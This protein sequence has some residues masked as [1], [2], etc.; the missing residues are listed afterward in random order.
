MAELILARAGHA[1]H[2]YIYDARSFVLG[3]GLLQGCNYASNLLRMLPTFAVYILFLNRNARAVSAHK[4]PPSFK[5]CSLFHFMFLCFFVAC[6]FLFLE[7]F[8]AILFLAAE[9]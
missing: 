9:T 8:I 6:P 2:M 3:D 7:N 1:V 5:F 4:A